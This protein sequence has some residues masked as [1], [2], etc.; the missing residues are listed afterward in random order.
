V[1]RA[2]SQQG[3]KGKNSGGGK[4]K[5]TGEELSSILPQQTPNQHKSAKK[6]KTTP[7]TLVMLGEKKGKK[8]CQEGRKETSGKL[9]ASERKKVILKSS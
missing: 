3:K 4:R 7:Q 9:A 8:P 1:I 6:Q 2:G 5:K